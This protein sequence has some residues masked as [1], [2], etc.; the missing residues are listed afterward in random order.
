MSKPSVEFV[1]AVA[2]DD[3]DGLNGHTAAV[4]RVDTGFDDG[5]VAER[6]KG[7]EGAHSPGA[8]GGQEYRGDHCV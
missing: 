4:K 5:L 1:C 6:E 2:E 8:T 3:D 7:F